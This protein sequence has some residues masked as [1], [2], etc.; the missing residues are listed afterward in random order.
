MNYKEAKEEFIQ[1]W[2]SLGTNWGIPKAM[3]EIHALLLASENPLSTDEIMDELKVSRSNANLN[4]RALIDWS[5]IYKKRIPGERKEYFVAEKDIWEVAVR[6]IKERR[7]REVDPVI[8]ELK[9]L[10]SFEAESFEEKNFKN[11][12]SD[13]HEL[14]KKMNT[15]GDMV[16][17][18][19][20]L[21]FVKWVVKG[22]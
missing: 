3:A 1:L 13:T 15:I 6:I 2:G 4:I 14:A 16:E 8:R 17:R 7:R 5:L 12:L 21:N 9:N 22:F 11:L 19:E 10:S 18:A 20:K